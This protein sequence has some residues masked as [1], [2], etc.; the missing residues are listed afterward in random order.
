[1]EVYLLESDGRLWD[2]YVSKHPEGTLYHLSA[3]KKVIEETYSHKTYYFYVAE[4]DSSGSRFITGILPLAH[5]R[6]FL[7]GN[8]L[9]SI[10]YFDMAGIL[11]DNDDAFNAL[12]GKARELSKQL[13]VQNLEF[14][15]AKNVEAFKSR[16]TDENDMNGVIWQVKSQKVRMVLP[17]PETTDELWASF[18]S[19][20]RNKIRKPQKEGVTSAIGKEELL[21]DFYDVFCVNMRDL[22]SPVH[23]KHLFLNILQAFPETARIIVAYKSGEP[24]ACGFFIGFRDQLENPWSSFL[25]SFS[26]ARAN[27]LIYWEMLNYGVLH[28]HKTF[29]FGRSTVGQGTHEFKTQ[30]GAIE[31]PL[32]WYSFGL[33]N[34]VTDKDEKSRF[35]SFIALW[36]KLPVPVATFVGPIIRKY[37][38]L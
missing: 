5:L 37:I 21:D 3:W 23:P 6:H 34:Q 20:H 9:I 2:E 16:T 7:F 27:Y 22:G 26:T 15:H 12:I 19:K 35:E 14:R 13:N 4:T 18:K 24:I 8:H 32:F 1:M 36:Q 31:T 28:G 17:L 29:D 33:A 30:W 10:P 38:G 11:Y 25:R